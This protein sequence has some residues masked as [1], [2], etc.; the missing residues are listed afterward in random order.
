PWREQTQDL[1]PVLLN[2]QHPRH[3]FAG[4]AGKGGPPPTGGRA[5]DHFVRHQQPSR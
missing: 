4:K 3:R 5:G 2:L 1:E